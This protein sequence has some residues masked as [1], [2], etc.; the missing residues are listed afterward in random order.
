MPSRGHFDGR[1]MWAEVNLKALVHNFRAIRQ[2]LDS[3]AGAT[4]KI[5]GKD[6]QAPKILAIVKANAYGH[7]AVPVART[8]AKAGADYL[9]VT[10]SAEGIELREGGVHK[11]ILLLTGFWDG[12]ENSVIKNKLTPTITR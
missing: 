5:D 4:A 7:G 2:H 3:R 11:P 1:P 8:L 9:G 12:E 10:C 6:S